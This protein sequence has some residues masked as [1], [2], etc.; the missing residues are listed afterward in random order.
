MAIKQ[1]TFEGGTL[2][3]NVLAAQAG[4]GDA[5]DFVTVTNSATI[6]Y[7]TAQAM[8]GTK[9]AKVTPTATGQSSMSYA[10]TSAAVAVR[11]YL[12]MTAAVAG[13]TY[14][15]R[16]ETGAQATTAPR[17]V[18]K[19]TGKI[20]LQDFG[21]ATAWTSTS[22]IPLNQWVRLELFASAGADATTGTLKGGMYLGD[23]T[24]PIDPIFSSTTANAGTA[25]FTRAAVAKTNASQTYA[26]AFWVD[27]FA[28]NDG[29]TDL[30][31]VG[32]NS[33]PVVTAGAPATV[34]PGAAFTL[35]F[36]ATDADGNT[37]TTSAAAAAGNPATLGTLTVGASSVTGTAPATAGK[38]TINLTVSD[39][40]ATVVTPLTLN[41]TS[42]TAVPT[43]V[44][45]NAGSWVASNGNIVT[46]LADADSATYVSS[47]DNPA[48]NAF[49]VT[50]TPY[51]A[52][53]TARVSYTLS[54]NPGSPARSVTVGLYM[55]STL[56][57]SKTE[58]ALT[59]TPTA[60]FFD[61]T[62]AQLAAWTDRSAP[63]IRFTA[64]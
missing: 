48:G 3:G 47:P 34:A 43:A 45:S 59:T 6:T 32:A 7:D 26:A 5:L 44:T 25:A 27:D 14:I 54:Q 10:V 37:L 64:N 35:P 13:D 1:N 46:A 28:V 16:L 15:M 53:A 4:S 49:G 12:Y 40:T 63:E 62:S 51:T 9:S 8:H 31:G 50:I 55:G 23:S 17:F 56:I 36:T 11:A 33:A 60:G 24:T 18:L 57:A 52:G 41:V 20:V 38:Y 39:G 29:A 21:A 30:I 58:S 2:G 61:L 19:S 42:S 22:S